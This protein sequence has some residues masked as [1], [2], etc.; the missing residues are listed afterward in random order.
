MTEPCLADQKTRR[1]TFEPRLLL[2]SLV[3]EKNWTRTG[4]CLQLTYFGFPPSSFHQFLIDYSFV[5]YFTPKLSN[6]SNC[7]RPWINTF[8]QTDIVNN[9][10]NKW[11]AGLIL[12]RTATFQV[13][14]NK[15][16]ILLN[17]K[18]NKG[19]QNSP[20]TVY[21]LRQKFIPRRPSLIFILILSSLLGLGLPS[22]LLPSCFSAHV[23]HSPPT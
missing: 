23:S 14:Q 6:L 19:L 8:L 16:R 1:S 15:F 13:S 9:N 3:V 12:L 18:I 22:G 4:F 5:S 17:Q 10:P 2:V 7:Q 11:G 21:S 20:P